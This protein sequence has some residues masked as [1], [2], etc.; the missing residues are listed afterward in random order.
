[1]LWNIFSVGYDTNFNFL[2]YLTN[3]TPFNTIV[4]ILNAKYYG[5]LTT[6]SKEIVKT[7]G[8]KTKISLDQLKMCLNENTI[9]NIS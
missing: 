6:D 7:K 5:R 8:L 4:N 1:M 9:H 3:I 2:F